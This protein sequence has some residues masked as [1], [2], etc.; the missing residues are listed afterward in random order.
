MHSL[1]VASAA[2]L[3]PFFVWLNFSNVMEL[4]FSPTLCSLPRQKLW[5]LEIHRES[6]QS[7]CQKDFS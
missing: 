2:P 4:Q 1:G 3:F 6:Q 7:Y 5:I